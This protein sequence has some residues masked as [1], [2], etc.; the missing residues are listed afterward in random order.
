MAKAISK[1]WEQLY[2]RLLSEKMKERSEKVI[3]IIA[4]AG[5]FI[6]LSLIILNKLDIFESVNS[7][8]LLDNPIAAIYTPFSFILVYEVYLLVYFLPKSITIYIGKQYEIILLVLIRRLFK[9]LAQLDL[10]SS[11]FSSK[12]DL[13]FTYDIG[14]SIIIFALIFI[15]YYLNTKRTSAQKKELSKREQTQRFIETKKRFSVLLI[16]FLFGLAVYSFGDYFYEV[17]FSASHRIDSIKN[18]NNIFFDEFFTI[19]ILSDV[20]LLLISYTHTSSFRSVIRN[21]GFVISTILIKISFSTDGIL[22]D[23][24]VVSAITFGVLILWIHNFYEKI[25]LPS[26]T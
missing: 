13:Q 20:L 24:L 16:P 9:D 6:H 15:F 1:F 23:I 3:I 22:N 12:D 8:S 5:F 10:E 4:I 21:S 17:F 26:D 18:T 11:W 19:L 7:S 14:T 25:E 2:Q